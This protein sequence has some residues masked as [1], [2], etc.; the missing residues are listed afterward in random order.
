MR[1]AKGS[2]VV[3]GCRVPL[4]SHRRSHFRGYVLPEPRTDGCDG[5]VRACRDTR[6]SPPS[7]I[8][9]PT[10]LSLPIDVRTLLNRP[11][12]CSLVGGCPVTVEEARGGKEA[13]PRPDRG[14]QCRPGCARGLL[15]VS[16]DGL[17][18]TPDGSVLYERL[19]KEVRGISAKV[20]AGLDPDDLAAAYR[21]HTVVTERA[22]SM[23]TS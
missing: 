4:Q 16:T 1:A 9:D 7:A 10:I 8:F 12:R 20:W 19:D 2:H 11:G 13:R 21:V 6:R 17:T 22:N 15:C 5:H 14:H 18:T 3:S 23:L